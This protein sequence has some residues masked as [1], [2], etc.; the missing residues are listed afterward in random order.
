MIYGRVRIHPVGKWGHE[1]RAPGSDSAGRQGTGKHG[2]A[3]ALQ[4]ERRWQKGSS[5][6]S[7]EPWSPGPLRRP[8]STS[9]LTSLTA[10]PEAL[11]WCLHHALPSTQ[12]QAGQHFQVTAEADQHRSSLLPVQRQ[13]EDRNQRVF[14]AMRL[15]SER[16]QQA[17][18]RRGGRPRGYTLKEETMDNSRQITDHTCQRH[19]KYPNLKMCCLVFCCLFIWGH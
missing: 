9:D 17:K 13:R 18:G 10:G 16:Q 3:G 19:E 7:A 4:R 11:T 12:H 8:D 5:C 14:T 6:T 1:G 15:S 2:E